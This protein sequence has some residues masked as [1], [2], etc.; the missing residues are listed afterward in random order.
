M[1][2]LVTVGLCALVAEPIL[3]SVGVFV[4]PVLAIVSF[5][6]P[7][8]GLIMLAGSQIISNAPGFPLTPGLTAFVGFLVSLAYRRYDFRNSLAIFVRTALPYALWIMAIDFLHGRDFHT[9]IYVALIVCA[10]ACVLI[11]QRGVRTDVAVFALCLG[12]LAS[13]MGWWGHVLG[14]N[15]AGREL[16]RR[17]MLRIVTGRLAGISAFPSALSTVGCLGLAT[18]HHS[19]FSKGQPRILMLTLAAA[20]A[21]SIPAAMGRGALL[22]LV[23]GC[24]LLFLYNAVALRHVAQAQRKTAII[25]LLCLVTTGLAFT[26]QT[27]STYLTRIFE[28]TRDQTSKIESVDDAAKKGYRTANMT[29]M[30]YMSALHPITGTPDDEILDTPWG[31]GTKWQ[32]M[33]YVPHNAFLGRAMTYGFTGMFIFIY[34]FSYPVYKLLK[35]PSTPETGTL[36]ACHGVFFVLFMFFPFGSFKIFYLLWAVESHYLTRRLRPPVTTR[37]G[38]SDGARRLAERQAAAS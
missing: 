24:T 38:G 3:N 16:I 30:L 11:S 22:A 32:L 15:V 4:L 13:S 37:M 34:F 36:L 18:W 2:V 35:L 29:K 1:M 28:M 8:S 17:G 26:N 20:T 7:Y 12:S 31:V 21:L 23:F 27:I 25:V 5:V 33:K 14:L 19:P 10:C 9:S 6:S